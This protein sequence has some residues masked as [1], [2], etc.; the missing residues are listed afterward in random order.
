VKAYELRAEGE[1]GAKGLGRLR[2]DYHHLQST[3]KGLSKMLPLV[4]LWIPPGI[5]LIPPLL[6]VYFPRQ[7]FTRHFWTV[8]SVASGGY[9]E[10]HLLT[11]EGL[12]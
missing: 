7:I 10:A 6:Y 11:S 2:R 8:R 9:P 12:R 1:G 3:L 5:G 4:I